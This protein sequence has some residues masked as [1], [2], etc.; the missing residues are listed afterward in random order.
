M[1][2]LIKL[3]MKRIIKEQMIHCDALIYPLSSN[4]YRC[5]VLPHVWSFLSLTEIPS[6]PFIIVTLDPERSFVG[7]RLYASGSMSIKPWQFFPIYPILLTHFKM[8][9]FT[10]TDHAFFMGHH[11]ECSQ[12]IC[13]PLGILIRCC[14]CKSRKKFTSHHSS[15]SLC[16]A[17]TE[18]WVSRKKMGTCV[19]AFLERASLICK[20]VPRLS[21]QN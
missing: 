3:W 14:R 5:I 17:C 13:W 12:G 7:M 2:T 15:T 21:S 1:G 4:K 11:W 19:H 9:L 16:T 20:M 18:P 8:L 6:V 10:Y